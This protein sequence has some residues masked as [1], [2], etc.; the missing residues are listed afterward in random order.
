MEMLCTGCKKSELA[1]PIFGVFSVPDIFLF[2]PFVEL[3]YIP[4]LS[5]LFFCKTGTIWSLIA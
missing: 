1:L 5:W 3:K 2:G 4:E